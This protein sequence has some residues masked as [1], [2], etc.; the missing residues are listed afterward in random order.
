MTFYFPGTD[1]KTHNQINRDYEEPKAIT[2]DYDYSAKNC[3]G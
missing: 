1:E 2:Y 3:K